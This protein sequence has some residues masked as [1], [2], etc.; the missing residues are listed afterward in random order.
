MDS[1]ERKRIFAKAKQLEASGLNDG[2]VH[3]YAQ[4]GAAEDAARLLLSERKFAEAANVFVH[5][6]GLAR[7]STLGEKELQ[8]LAG[9]QKKRALHA[10]ICFAKAG[11]RELA[12]RMF[13]GLGEVDRAVEMLKL[14]GDS[15]AAARL[16]ADFKRRGQFTDSTTPGA[17]GQRTDVTIESAKAL[18]DAGKYELAMEAYTRLKQLPHAARMARMAGKVAEAGE[19]FRDGGLPFEAALCFL[20]IGDTGLAIEHFTRVPREDPRYKEA[21]FQAIDLA[22]GIGFLDFSL[23]NF[24]TRFLSEPPA[25]QREADA[26]FNMAELYLRHDFAE[27]ARDAFSKIAEVAPEYRGAARRITA[28]DEEAKGSAM[29]YGKILEEDLAFQGN[30]RMRGSR[31]SAEDMPDLSDL[32]DL[33]D[34]PDAPS[35]AAPSRRRRRQATESTERNLDHGATQYV[36]EHQ[37]SS[38]AAQTL[39]PDGAMTAVRGATGGG[40]QTLEGV[41]VGTIPP[42]AM[43]ELPRPGAGAQGTGYDAP[44][45]EVLPLKDSDMFPTSDAPEQRSSSNL[46]VSPPPN[47][48][49]FDVGVILSDRYRFEKKVGEGGMA[50]VF[51][52]WDLELEEHVAIKVFTREVSDEGA[53]ARFKQELSLSRRLS[54]PNIIRLYDIG[55]WHGFRYISM[56]LLLGRDLNDYVDRP[57]ELSVGLDWLIQSAEGL[58]GAHDKGVIHRDIK[59]HNIFVCD[60]GVVKVM[61]FGIAKRQSAQGV[62][63]GNMIAG[64]PDYMSPEQIHGFSS[65]THSTDIYALGVVAYQMFTG[66]L[67]FAHEE[68]LPLLMMHI[69]DVP[70]PPTSRNRDLPEELERIILRLLEKKPEDR[71]SSSAALADALRMFQS[72]L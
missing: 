36:P 68:L 3:A 69:N 63:V 6:L 71:F 32:P 46:A 41:G 60:D 65:V 21:A 17:V 38:D 1:A 39:G 22:A 62:T 16:E 14:A 12:I 57:L 8:G 15:V 23:E 30:D 31:G 13:V 29:V 40:T 70:P 24:L 9:T 50:A 4:C 33:P 18:E 52:A 37:K 64:T 55:S 10:A 58:Q 43:D 61:D 42:V 53:V 66:T 25:N 20:E 28:I 72:R 5:T 35:M 19:L 54:H 56:E 47:F 59:P 11:Q 27:N 48:K 7:G 49:G 44:S 26:F 45:V 51:K 34:L 2:A 67:P